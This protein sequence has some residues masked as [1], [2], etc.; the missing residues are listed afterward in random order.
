MLIYE[1]PY[2]SAYHAEDDLMPQDCVEEL[3]EV[4]GVDSCAFASG[5]NN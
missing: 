1:N 3:G 4:E 5:K 2:M